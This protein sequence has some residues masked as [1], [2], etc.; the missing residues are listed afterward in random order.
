MVLPLPETDAPLDTLALHELTHILVGEIIWPERPGDGGMPQ[1]V[2]EGVA[3]YMVGVWRDEDE[4]VM[5]E[6]VA[7]R[8]V[9]ALSTLSGSGGFTNVRVNDA[10]G[11][12]A[13]DYI[14][15]RWGPNSVRRFLDALIM[16]RVSK[17][18]DAVFE[19]TPA[20]FDVAFRQYAEQRFGRVAR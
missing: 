8:Q 7:S 6:L 13:F 2:K 17:T 9:P 20:E 19:L 18:Y 3:S 1:W 5:R 12:A 16:P 15:S 10:V 11:H 4:R 14:E